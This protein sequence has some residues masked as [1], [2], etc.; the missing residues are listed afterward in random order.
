LQSPSA[1]NDGVD[2]SNCETN[3]LA[4]DCSCQGTPPNSTPDPPCNKVAPGSNYKSWKASEFE[5]LVNI[6][7]ELE[8]QRDD[9]LDH[10]MVVVSAGNGGLDLTTNGIDLIR[11]FLPKAFAHMIIVGGLNANGQPERGFNHSFS[12]DQ[13][14]YAPGVN[15]VVPGTNGCLA[16]GTSFAAPAVAGLVSQLSQA[17]PCLT[18]AQLKTAIQNAATTLSGGLPGIPLLG[19]PT[20]QAAS[21]AAKNLVPL[22]CFTLNI[23]KTG[24]GTGTVNTTPPPDQPGPPPMYTKGTVVI[25]AAV[26]DTGSTFVG[27]SG[28]A[29]GTGT[30]TSVTMDSNK[31]VIATFDL[32]SQSLA[33]TS[34]TWTPIYVNG[35][36]D[37]YSAVVTGTA[38]GPIG[39]SLG[40]G[41]AIPTSSGPRIVADSW[42]N[43]G[44]LPIRQSGD[45]ATTTWTATDYVFAV[46]DVLTISLLN[47]GTGSFTYVYAHP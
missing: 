9:L 26:P 42:N 1:P 2:R 28:D 27:W 5:T 23:T 21:D 7:G 33:I 3:P 39:S 46:G 15:V 10:T 25:L 44:F 37:H 4:T 12:T 6:A 40:A 32:G 34:Q 18:T 11:I 36:I 47:G 29:S 31:S 43:S 13:M 20:F 24:T 19:I 17:F 30:A 38:T 22:G 8:F 35:Q 16:N 14:L 45:P 41:V